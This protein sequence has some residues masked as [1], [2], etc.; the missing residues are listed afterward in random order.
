MASVSPFPIVDAK[1]NAV[2]IAEV[3]FAQVA[4]QMLL[5]TMLINALHAAFEN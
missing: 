1:R 3:K 5:S 2:G 4:V